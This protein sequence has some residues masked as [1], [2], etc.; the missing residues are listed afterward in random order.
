LLVRLIAPGKTRPE[1]IRDGIAEYAGRLRRYCRL[2]IVEL[3]EEPVMSKDPA[4]AEIVK[5]AEGTRILDALGARSWVVLLDEKGKELGSVAFAGMISKAML[6]GHGGMDFVMGGSLGVDGRVA[7]R[8]DVTVSLSRMT[9]TH[10]MARLVL[11]EQ[12][13]RAFTIIRGEKYHNP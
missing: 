13:Y 11:L 9:M 3:R 7:E 2:E 4:R 12:I 5:R 8:A 6:D 1:F 10:Q